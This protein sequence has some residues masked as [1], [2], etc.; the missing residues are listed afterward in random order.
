MTHTPGHVEKDDTRKDW[1]VIQEDTGRSR[2]D[3]LQVLGGHL[4]R[5]IVSNRAGD[6][7]AVAMVFV[8]GAG[9]TE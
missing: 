4:L 8:S 9:K 5:T 3:R 6:P 7:V 1:T 2:T